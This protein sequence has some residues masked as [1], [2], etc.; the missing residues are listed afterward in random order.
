MPT[1]AAPGPI[2]SGPQGVIYL[3]DLTFD[4]VRPRAAR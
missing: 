1:A 3:D 4:R 2:R